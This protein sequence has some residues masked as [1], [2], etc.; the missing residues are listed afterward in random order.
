V[1]LTLLNDL[2]TWRKVL[3]CMVVGSLIVFI[4]VSIVPLME[5]CRNVL[6]LK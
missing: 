3:W 6:F 2:L 4:V 5:V 1:L